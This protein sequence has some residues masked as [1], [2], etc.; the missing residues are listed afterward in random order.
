[1]KKLIIAAAIVCAAVVSQ[2]AAVGWNC[3]GATNFKGGDYSIFVVGMNGVTGTDQIKAIVAAGGLEAASAYAFGGDVVNSSGAATKASGSSGKSITWTGPGEENY[4]AFIFVQ[5]V[6]GEF[7]S[8][9]DVKSIT[10]ADN[11]T[12][13]TFQFQN[14]ATA[15]TANKFAVAPEP[16]SGLLLLLGVA[17]LALRRRRA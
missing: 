5:D 1:M 6:D 11:S 7:A 9:T 17:G 3:A 14:Q 10:M 2:A 13:K 16:T 15:F 8:Y 4:S 12:S